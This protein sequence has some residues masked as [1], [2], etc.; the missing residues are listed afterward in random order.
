[1]TVKSLT[2]FI[3]FISC[4]SATG[5]V[6]D[7][8]N[9]TD[10]KGLKQGLWIKKYPGGAIQYKGSFRDDKP[11]GEFIRYYENGIRMSLQVF[12]ENGKRAE[13]TLYHPNGYIS[14]QGLFIDQKKE[15]KWK[16]FSAYTAG[17]LIGEETFSENQRNGLSEKFYPD[18]AK[19]E[20]L[21]YKNDIKNGPWLKYYA[22]GS[23]MLRAGFK[24][25]KLDGSYEFFNEDGSVSFT[26]A[27]ANNLK[28]GKWIYFNKNGSVRYE[29]LYSG[30]ITTGTGLEDDARKLIDSLDN[31][32]GRIADPEI[33]GVIR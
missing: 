1:M 25:G 11:E 2:I 8:Q 30:G 14:S 16:Y 33:T 9:F 4:I 24:E 32:T 17:Y 20:S 18:G 7:A 5:Q 12:S 28:E 29:L 15:G 3:F 22:N 27:Y 21:N 10:S 23:I 13:T 31:N 26:G 19:G 6:P